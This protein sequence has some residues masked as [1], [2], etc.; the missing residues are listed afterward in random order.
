MAVQVILEDGFAAVAT[1]QD[2][3]NGAGVIDANLAGQA[4]TVS[5]SPRFVSRKICAFAGPRYD[6]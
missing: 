3:V 4:T 1:I 2:M 6:P 5:N